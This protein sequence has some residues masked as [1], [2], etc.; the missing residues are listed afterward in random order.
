[1]VISGAKAAVAAVLFQLVLDAEPRELLVS[2][3]S[4][5]H[6]IEPMLDAFEAVAGTVDYLAARITWVSSS[7]ADVVPGRSTPDSGGG[8]HAVLSGSPTR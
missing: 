6:L 1:M 5:S 7:T 4:H 8:K 2:H 3:A